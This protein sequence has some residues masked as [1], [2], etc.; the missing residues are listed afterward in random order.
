MGAAMA[1]LA[2]LRASASQWPTKPIR[3]IVPYAAGSATDLIPRTVFEAVS[4][5]VGQPVVV[6]NRLGGGTTVGTSAAAKAE[7]DGHTILVHS[8]GLV[9][10]PAIQPNVPYDPVRDFS[11]ITPLGNVPLVLVVAPE[12]NIATVEELVA[13]AR[14]KPGAINYAAAGI[15]TPPHLTA[16]RFRLAA[17]FEGQL[18]PFKGAPEALTEVLAGRVD[19]YFCPLPAAMAFISDGKLKALAVSGAK[20]A[21]ALPNVPTTLEAGFL[22]SDFD[23]WVGTLVPRQTPRDIVARLHAEIV[24]AVESASVQERLTK[25]GVEPMIL[26]PQQFDARIAKEAEIAVALAK[27]ANIALQ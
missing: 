8:N 23:F 1:P 20:R 3:V 2:G 18:V 6:E 19:F 17:G 5:Q 13:A 12:K 11:G 16:E 25:L 14:A 27:A 26:E 24:K 15:G 9:T 22:N 4:A 7:P 10:V 21:S